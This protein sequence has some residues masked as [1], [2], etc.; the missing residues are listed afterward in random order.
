MSITEAEKSILLGYIW[1][2]KPSDLSVLQAIFA[3]K[4]GN[5]GTIKGTNNHVFW[6][7]LVSKKLAQEE[8]PK[9][10]TRGKGF[11]FDR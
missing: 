9:I 1:A 11:F 7:Y 4:D 8:L 5:V 6:S 2:L 3:E 10:E